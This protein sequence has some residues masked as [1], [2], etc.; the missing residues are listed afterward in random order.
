MK[1]FLK[2]LTDF[3][4]VIF[5][6]GILIALFAGG[7]SA[8]GYVAAIIIGGDTAAAICDFIYLKAYPVL[9]YFT[10]SMIVLGLLCMYLRGESMFK[11]GKAKKNK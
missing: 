1:G 10:T 4:Q 3:M 6:Y 2:K 8:L 11:S 9:V 7:I 5:G